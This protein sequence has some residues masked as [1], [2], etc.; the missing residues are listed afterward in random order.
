MSMFRRERRNKQHKQPL[1]GKPLPPRTAAPDFRL[2]G[3]TDELMSLGDFAGRPVVLVFYPADW[4]TVCGD[5]LGL[6]NEILALFEQHHA[7][8]LAISVDSLWSHK[9]FAEQSNLRFPL[10]ADFHPKGAVAKAYGVY[11]EEVGVSRRALFVVDAAGIIRWTYVSPADVNPGA[12]G[13]LSA[14]E[15]LNS[16]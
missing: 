5:Q 8:L 1:P 16:S 15:N 12:D 14:L 13:I 7:Q 10:L 6:Y 9:A 11:D 4:S 3:S 2:W